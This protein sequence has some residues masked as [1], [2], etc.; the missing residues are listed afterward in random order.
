MKKYLFKGLTLAGIT[1]ALILFKSTILSQLEYLVP[2]VAIIVAALALVK[3]NWK[4]AVFGALGAAVLTL[5]WANL[6]THSMGIYVGGLFIAD[7][8]SW[9]LVLK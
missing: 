3:M 8:V 9:K 4:M 1:V 7:L 6:S 5:A 2:L